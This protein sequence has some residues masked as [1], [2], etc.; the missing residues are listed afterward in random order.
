MTTQRWPLF[1]LL[2]AL[3]IVIAY[4]LMGRIVE[5]EPYEVRLAKPYIDEIVV[6]DG[7]LRELA[8]A[9]VQ[10]YPEK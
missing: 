7:E 2:G 5:I 1:L 10:D 4:V 9:L 3:A 6:D 8:S